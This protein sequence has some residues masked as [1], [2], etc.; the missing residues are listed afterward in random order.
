MALPRQLKVRV[1]ICSSGD[2]FPTPVSMCILAMHTCAHSQPLSRVWPAAELGWGQAGQLAGVAGTPPQPM[3]RVPAGRGLRTLTP[4]ILMHRPGGRARGVS[5]P[6]CWHWVGTGWALGVS[7]GCYAHRTPW[8]GAEKHRCPA[9]CHD[10]QGE[11]LANRK[12]EPARGSAGPSTAPQCPWD[13]PGDK[14]AAP[15]TAGWARC[16]GKP[17][18]H[19]LFVTRGVVGLLQFHALCPAPFSPGSLRTTCRAW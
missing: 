9:A 5:G 8:F 4:H 1:F 12:W 3:S 19:H 13:S 6:G 7:W 2:L 11:P 18:F 17:S 14:G 10:H 16:A 15:G